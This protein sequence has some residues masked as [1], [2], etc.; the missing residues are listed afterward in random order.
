MTVSSKKAS[1]TNLIGLTAVANIFTGMLVFLLLPV[2]VSEIADMT[3][4][5]WQIILILGAVQVGGGYAFYNLGVQRI[6]PH[7]A[8][9]IALWELILGPI[10]VALFLREYPS[11]MVWIGLA[12]IL[13]GMVQEVKMSQLTIEAGMNIR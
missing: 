3:R 1:G 7:K 2:P 9:I 8:S 12:I 6:L 10:W 4:L 11:L 5:D 13:L